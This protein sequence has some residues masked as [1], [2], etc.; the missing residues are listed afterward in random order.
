MWIIY[1]IMQAPRFLAFESLPH[2]E[3]CDVDYVAE[4]AQLTCRLGTAEEVF[5][6]AIEDIKTIPRTFQ[7]QITAYDTDIR[8]HD[9]IYLAFALSDKHHFVRMFGAFIV[10]VGHIVAQ[11]IA[12]DKAF[13]MTF[14]RISVYHS[15]YKR[16]GGKTV[17]A[18]KTR[19]AAFAYG[20]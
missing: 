6:L 11:I 15:L 8:A 5:G 17:T 16:I 4:L 14:G 18:V 2:H 3:I 20:I 7:T 19:A 12:T 1:R 10:P 9:G 13:G